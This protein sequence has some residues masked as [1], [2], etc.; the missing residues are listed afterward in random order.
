MVVNPWPPTRFSANIS[1]AIAKLVRLYS[2]KG[3]NLRFVI[4]GHIH[5]ACIAD[6]Y[7]RSSSLV[8]GNSYSENGLMLTSRAS[9][10]IHI[11]YDNGEIDSIKVD[12]QDVENIVGYPIQEELEAY[13]AKSASKIKESE[14]IIKIII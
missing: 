6:M 2:D 13:N 7:S 3:I 1:Q 10:N 4:F 12:L 5:E 8:G 14:T 11:Q 9:Q